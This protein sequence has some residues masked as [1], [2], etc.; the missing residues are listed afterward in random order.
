MANT[1]IEIEAYHGT[2]KDN[3]NNILEKG[4]TFNRRDDHWLGQGIYFYDDIELARWFITRK[5]KGTHGKEIFV[6]KSTLSTVPEKVLNLDTNIG[7]DFVYEKVS[8]LISEINIIF[9]KEDEIKNR[10]IILDIIKELYNIDIIIMTFKTDF[11]SYGR[12]RIKWFEDNYFP[13][14]I[15]YSETQICAT[16]NDCIK[17]NVAVNNLKDYKL[18]NKIWFP[19]NRKR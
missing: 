8:Q 4:Y 10:C 13:I 11:Q 3:V 14:G 5:Y 7:V 12:A 15:N 16:D 9:D 2:F 6:I 19:K 18:A 1:T 17:N